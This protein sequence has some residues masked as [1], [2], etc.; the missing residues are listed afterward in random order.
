MN[1]HEVCESR[2]C[3]QTS[4]CWS[5]WLSGDIRKTQALPGRLFELFV[6]LLLSCLCFQ[7]ELNTVSLSHH[8]CLRHVIL[9]WHE[10]CSTKTK[11]SPLH[12]RPCSLRQF[13]RPRRWNTEDMWAK[14]PPQT[15]ASVRLQ[16]GTASAL[17]RSHCSCFASRHF[18]E[19]PLTSFLQLFP[20][21]LRHCLPIAFYRKTHVH[22]STHTYIASTDT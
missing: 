22:T 12:L 10:P 7:S 19:I 8:N 21:D 5:R 14:S 15:S 2:F 9:W 16:R 6:F 4:L 18:L 11:S 3:W 13:Q 17:M 20:S 1:P